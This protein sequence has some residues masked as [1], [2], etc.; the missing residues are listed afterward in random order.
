MTLLQLIQAALRGKVTVPEFT[1]EDT[2]HCGCLLEPG[3]WGADGF[4]WARL[5]AERLW[6]Q[7]KRRFADARPGWSREALRKEWSRWCGREEDAGRIG[8]DGLHVNM[9]PYLGLPVAVEPCGAYRAKVAE[10]LEQEAARKTP[11]PKAYERP[12][13]ASWSGRAAAGASE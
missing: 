8:A 10:S 11:K 7:E 5:D 2:T 9:R 4:H 1:P 12:A 13:N 6:L 3:F